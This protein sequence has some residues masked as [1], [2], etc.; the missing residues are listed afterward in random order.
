MESAETLHHCIKLLVIF[1]THPLVVSVSLKLV[2]R[3]VVQI[4][5]VM[6]TFLQE[7]VK[8]EW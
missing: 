4:E 2:E 5:V 1:I 3:A 7:M 6:I 8:S